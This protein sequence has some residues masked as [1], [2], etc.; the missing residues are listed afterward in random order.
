[1]AT[2][3]SDGTRTCATVPSC[4]GVSEQSTWIVTRALKSLGQRDVGDAADRHAADLHLVASD[5]LA[6]FFEDQVVVGAA[7]AAEHEVGDDQHDERERADGEPAHDARTRRR[8]RGRRRIAS[9]EGGG[10]DGAGWGG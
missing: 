5:E 9:G 6:G 7:A 1:M 2:L 3:E 8:A 10:E 4:S